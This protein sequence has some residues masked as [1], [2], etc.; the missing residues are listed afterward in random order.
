MSNTKEMKTLIEGFGKFLNEGMFDDLANS[1]GDIAQQGAASV[2][3][4]P[5]GQELF[6]R[7]LSD[8]QAIVIINDIFDNRLA[9][10]LE[11]LEMKGVDKNKFVVKF[12]K[13]LF[14]AQLINVI[15]PGLKHNVENSVIGDIVIQTLDEMEVLWGIFGF[16]ADV[17]KNEVKAQINIAVQGLLARMS[18]DIIFNE[19]N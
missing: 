18:G 16:G 9:P 17:E 15:P 3:S 11:Y 13:N 6:I 5:A 8:T 14:A 10:L 7:A 19:S 1:L 4:N 2:L 12:V